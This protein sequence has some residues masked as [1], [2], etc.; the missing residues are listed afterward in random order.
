MKQWVRNFFVGKQVDLE[1]L[2]KKI[3]ETKLF[4]FFFTFMFIL[5]I[6][7]DIFTYLYM[8]PFNILFGAMFVG[9]IVKNWSLWIVYNIG[10]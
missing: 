10:R 7:L 5:S 4:A 3:V 9:L 1:L 2:E 6:G 8:T